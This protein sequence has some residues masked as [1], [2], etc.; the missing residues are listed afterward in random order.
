MCVETGIK[1]NSIK[2]AA[3]DLDTDNSSIGK[4]LKGIRKTAAG[5]H[6]VYCE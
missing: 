4:V 1:Y 6:W 3:K 2:E 5:F